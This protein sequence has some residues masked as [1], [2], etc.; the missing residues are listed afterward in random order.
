MNLY[1]TKII[2]CIK[3][4]KHIGE[5]DYDAEVMRP[6]CGH[7][8]NLLPYG[9]DHLSYTLSSMKNKQTKSTEIIP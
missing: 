9:D 2:R 7:C 8:A 6:E 3:C 1:D 5:I 4:D